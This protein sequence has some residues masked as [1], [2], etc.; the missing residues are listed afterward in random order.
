MD[1][2]RDADP[3]KSL[4]YNVYMNDFCKMDTSTPY[5]YAYNLGHLLQSDEIIHTE[6][7]VVSP[8]EKW[9]PIVKDAIQMT[10]GD[11]S[12]YFA[13]AYLGNGLHEAAITSAINASTRALAQFGLRPFV[14]L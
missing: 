13:G 3:T 1:L 9:E 12:T 10:A 4:G 2:F 8:M 11:Q 6:N 14:S 5:S 7:H